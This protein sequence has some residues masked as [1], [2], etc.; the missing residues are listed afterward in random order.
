[1]SDQAVLRST[2]DLVRG[3][4]N[5]LGELHLDKELT[6]SLLGLLILDE[7]ELK[8]ANDTIEELRKLYKEALDAANQPIG[9]A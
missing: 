8:I 9:L 1:M 5:S 3:Q 2:L 7:R 4:V 6:S